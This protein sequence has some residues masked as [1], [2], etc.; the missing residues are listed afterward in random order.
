VNG[1]I[2][3]LYTQLGTTST[4]KAIADLHTLH[5]TRV[6]C[7]SSQYVFTSRFLITDLNNGDSSDSVV[8]PLPAG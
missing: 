4:Y 8:T 3:H 1:F 7:K 6:H 5:S 2:V